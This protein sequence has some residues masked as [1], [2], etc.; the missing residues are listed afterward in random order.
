MAELMVS[1]DKQ[2]K[3][4]I[5]IVDDKVENLFVLRQVLNQIDCEVVEC[6]SAVDALNA[7][8][9]H[10]FACMLLDVQM[11]GMDGF[12]LATEIKAKERSQHTPII[13]ISAALQELESILK[14]YE[15][16]AIDYLLKPIN[17]EILLAKVNVFIELDYHKQQAKNLLQ[18][19][20]QLL[21]E[22]EQL[23]HYDSLTNLYNRRQF[24]KIA[25]NVRNI[26]QRY[27][28]Q[29][30]FILLD[31]DGFKVI[32]DTRG[33]DV[34]DKLLVKITSRLR[35]AMR[36]TE[37]LAR[38]GGDECAIIVPKV[39]CLEDVGIIAGELVDTLSQPYKIGKHEIKVSA[40]LG[41]AC[42]P[43]A[44]QNIMDLFKKADIAL[45]RAK[46]LGKNTFQFYSEDLNVIYQRHNQIGYYLSEALLREELQLD[47]QPCIDMK[48]GMVVGAEALLRWHSPHLGNVSPEEFIPV[49]EKSGAIKQIGFWVLEKACLAYSHWQEKF[50]VKQF[51]LAINVSPLQLLEKG[52]SKKALALF[53]EHKIDVQYVTLELTESA[54]EGDLI[55]IEPELLKLANKKCHIA[56]D[57]FGT[58]L[59]SL[60][61]LASLPV[62]IIK[63][64]KS[65]VSGIGHSKRDENIIDISI[66]LA[67][68]LNIT[69]IAEGVETAEQKEF[70][71]QHGYFSDSDT[72]LAQGFYY[73]Q[74][75]ND[76]VFETI[77]KEKR[78]FKS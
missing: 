68:K 19:Q 46:A 29:F 70:L 67:K 2:I 9:L 18:K 50:N 49:A 42:Y 40:S 32:N 57:D 21:Q 43:K 39:M 73:S 53:S 75:V 45:Y 4:A 66:T 7:C 78:Q 23:A 59:S 11:P 60:A 58:G 54:F 8:E 72:L 24:W 51:H 5:L 41:V 62:D 47:F 38:M 44:S 1:E 35:Q 71:I 61:R 56:I 25:E 15:S 6:L 63:I 74:A 22:L 17:P 36:K 37:I 31:I 10:D 55:D 33:H 69:V 12:E 77:L 27:H 13:F 65:F 16:G 20:E 48:T 14:G 76:T 30:A 34:G 52:F 3:P 64:D 26:A 28:E